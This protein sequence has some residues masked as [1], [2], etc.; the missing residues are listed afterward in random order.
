MAIAGT[1]LGV[2]LLLTVLTVPVTT[3]IAGAAVV[4]VIAAGFSDALYIVPQQT[5][6]GINSSALLAVPFF[7]LA[8]GLLNKL[9]MT[10]RIFNFAEALVGHFR[11]GLAQVN[12]L[13][14]LIFAGISGA[15]VAD[16]AGLGMVEVKA[17][18]ERGYSPDFAAAVTMASSIVG[19]IFPPSIPLVIY[20]F[21]SS[22][23]VGRLFL[24]G[25]LPAIVIVIGLMSFIWVLS[26]RQKFPTQPRASLGRILRTG[27]DG[28]IALVAPTIIIAAMVTGFT[29]ASEAGVIACVYTLIAGL[30]Y[31]T[32]SWR[33]LWEA[34][35][36]TTLLTSMILLMLGFSTVMGWVMAI[37]QVPQVLAEAVLTTIDSVWVF[38]LAY[39]LFFLVIGCVFDT[40]AAMIILM[41][42]LLPLIDQ[43]S[44]DRVHF[45]I[46]TVFALMI[47]ILTPPL[48]IALYIMMDVS[49]LSFERLSRAAIPFL[50]PLVIV[51][52]IIAYVPEI[53]LWLPDMIMGPD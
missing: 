44:I 25:I 19:P 24:A 2:F 4:G 27:V 13:A 47:G 16:C 1:I 48:G 34:L 42:I 49:K 29:T 32:L 8:G 53:S 5:L 17:M 3:A 14:S 21:V 35:T 7:I 50:I 43:F 36:E 9:G 15:A 22:T 20:A 11:A 31:R 40:L 28:V 38:L 23:S 33:K 41:P 45:G 46:V 51:L 10:D 39:I 26:I 6:E 30:F 52:I 37:E 12:V 18:R